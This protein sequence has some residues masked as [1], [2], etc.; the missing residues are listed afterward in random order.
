MQPSFDPILQHIAET[1]TAAALAS[2]EAEAT[3]AVVE[4]SVEKK[5]VDAA[6]A[7]K[8]NGINATNEEGEAKETVTYPPPKPKEI[9]PD[10]VK[11][12]AYRIT[13]SQIALR[14]LLQ[15][16]MAIIPRSISEDHL[17]ENMDVVSVRE[18]A[19]TKEEMAIVDSIQYLVESQLSVAVNIE[20]FA[21]IQN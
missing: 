4:K 2:T 7:A 14:W 18:I 5:E 11:K 6:P 10:V 15:H 19:L 8:L 12:P 16:N 21:E 3:A 13:T 9:V 1:K 20:H 17:K